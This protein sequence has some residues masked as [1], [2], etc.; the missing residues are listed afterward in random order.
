MFSDGTEIPV[1][2]LTYG[3]YR[4]YL[5]LQ[6]NDRFDKYEILDHIYKKCVLDPALIDYPDKDMRAGIPV[7]TANAIL[8]I[9]S[10]RDH[11]DLIRSFDVYRSNVQDIEEQ[12]KMI[13]LAN[14]PSYKLSD[15]DECSFD[16]ILRLFAGAE[17][18][19]T[20]KEWR[21]GQPFSFVNRDEQTDAQGGTIS[22]R[23]VAEQN[24][25]IN[26]G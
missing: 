5:D 3:E 10:P 6:R 26:R 24:I 25:A 13:V 22:N 9:S 17:F 20:S 11:D 14:F 16:T 18:L 8:F 21:T 23:D 7:A 12:M 15:L 1:R 2:S 4:A 19:E